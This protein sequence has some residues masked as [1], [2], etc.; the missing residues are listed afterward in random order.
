[1]GAPQADGN[2]LDPM[3]DSGA[4]YLFRVVDGDSNGGGDGGDGGPDA[5]GAWTQ[6]GPMRAFNPDP[7][8]GFGWSVALSAD[9]GRVAV[10][11]FFES[12]GAPGVDGDEADDGTPG[13]GA[14]YTFLQQD[15]NLVPDHYVKASNPSSGDN[16]GHSLALSATGETLVVAGNQEDSAAT[17]MNGDESDNSASRSGA[18]Y[19][20]ERAGESWAQTAY[21]KASNTD[22]ADNFGYQIALSDSGDTLLVG[23]MGESAGSSGVSEASGDNERADSGALY[24]FQRVDGF[25]SEVLFAKETNSDAGDYLGWSVAMSGAGD[26]FAG[27][28]LGRVERGSRG[29]PENGARRAS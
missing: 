8:D 19:I 12:S 5:W 28:R 26:V 1:M 16:F 15:Q 14:V 27:R 10:G 22:P 7:G 23:A 4:A 21:I 17:G 20:F 6:S 24:G 2:A 9:G 25:W 3:P 18:V 11:A 29:R 13:A